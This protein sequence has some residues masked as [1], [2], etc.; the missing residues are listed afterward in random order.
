MILDSNGV[1][2]WYRQADPSSK[3]VLNLDR[4]SDGSLTW[5]ETNGAPWGNDPAAS[6]DRFALDGTPLDTYQTR[7][8]SADPVLRLTDQH[9]IVQMPNGNILMI[10]YPVRIAP[11]PFDCFDATKDPPPLVSTTTVLD[12]VIQE[13]NPTTNALVKEWRADVLG[14]SPEDR[15]R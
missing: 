12:A 8:S 11:V 7:P 5:T 15:H 2:V 14:A 3:V 1:P 10:S 6:I 4:W 13:I 9:D